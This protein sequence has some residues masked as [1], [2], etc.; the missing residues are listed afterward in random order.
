MAKKTKQ[1]LEE[2]TLPI[3][4][5]YTDRQSVRT[6]FRLSEAGKDA[7]KW[8]AKHHGITA[9]DVFDKFCQDSVIEIYAD[10][11]SK[12]RDDQTPPKKSV[13][14]TLV[15]SKG[16]LKTLN[17]F[18]TKNQIPR[19][20]LVDS[21]LIFLQLVTKEVLKKEQENNPRAL[22]IIS[23]FITQADSVEEKLTEILVSY[24]PIVDRFG[25]V[26]VILENLRSAIKSNLEDGT[27]IDPDDF[28]QS[29]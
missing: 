29:C 3:D 10:M 4:I 8:L 6:S 5:N 14:K 28:S 7:L 1:N 12:T 11:A 27:P 21:S 25:S 2:K 9:K 20:E 22:E 15:I 19:D 16:A 24:S 17:D 18:S 23:E 13:R 26:M